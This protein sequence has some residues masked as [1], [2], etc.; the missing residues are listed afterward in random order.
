MRRGAVGATVVVEVSGCG[1]TALCAE[2][3]ASLGI[4]SSA[5]VSFV[6]ICF[7][8]ASPPCSASDL[9]DASKVSLTSS[10]NLGAVL[11]SGMES[12]FLSI[13]FNLGVS[14]GVEEACSGSSSG[15]FFFS[16]LGVALGAP[17]RGRFLIARSLCRLDSWSLPDG[18]E[19]LA[20]GE[21]FEATFSW[22]ALFVAALDFSIGALTDD[23]LLGVRRAGAAL[24]DTLVLGRLEGLLEIRCRLCFDFSSF[25][26]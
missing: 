12:S 4:F 19:T 3:S 24:V 7:F 2:G 5:A 16:T 10:S 22:S 17:A 9:M 6:A 25:S 23:G 26:N 8:M 14:I 1:V 11:F 13:A 20:G 21:A 15:M 18:F